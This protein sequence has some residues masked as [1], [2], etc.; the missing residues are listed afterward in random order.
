MGFEP[1]TFS[2]EADLKGSLGEKGIDWVSFGKY[3]KNREFSSRW[4]S[5]VF[6]SAFKYSSCLLSSD[7]SQSLSCLRVCSQKF[8]QSL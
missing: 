3:L 7:L 5:Q 4:E 2:L 6:N 8:L 1:M